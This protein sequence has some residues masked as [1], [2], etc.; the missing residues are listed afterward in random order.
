MKTNEQIAVLYARRYFKN[1]V[2]EDRT[3]ECLKSYIWDAVEAATDP[4]KLDNRDLKE[5]L[6]EVI[7]ACYGAKI[8]NLDWNII[9][10]AQDLLERLKK[11]KR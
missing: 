10:S 6:K 7:D 11:E 2:S 8:S 9:E 3:E 4:M 1:E 5:H